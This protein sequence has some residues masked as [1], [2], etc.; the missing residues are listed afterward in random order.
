MKRLFTT[1]LLLVFTSALLAQNSVSTFERTGTLSG[2]IIDATLGQP[3]PYV[4]IVIKNLNEDTLS[5][6][7]TDD[8]GEFKVGDLPEGKVNVSIQFLGYK[9]VNKEVTFSSSN[10][11]VDIGTVFLEEEATLPRR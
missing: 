4:T 2:K 10:W 6:S 3:I 5:G 7:I 11:R 8:K 1:F 9:T